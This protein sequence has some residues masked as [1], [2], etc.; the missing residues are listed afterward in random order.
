[1]RIAAMEK[2]TMLDFP[3]KVSALLFTSA[4]NFCCPYCHNPDLVVPSR[5][6]E[7]EPLDPAE[8]WSFLEKRR[9]ILQGIAITGGEPTLQPD[10][11]DF[12]KRIKSLGYAVKTDTNG[13]N[14]RMLKALFAEKVLD[15]IAMDI[16]AD[17]A[18]YP[19]EISPHPLGNTLLDSI[20][21][22]EASGIPHEFRI[23]CAAPFI[24]PQSFAVILSYIAPE[25]PIYLQK[26]TLTNVLNPQ[27]FVDKK[28]YSLS[29]NEIAALHTQGLE[30]GHNVHIRGEN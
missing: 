5:L 26:I 23:P 16:K 28:G 15:Y 9:G 2:L 13:T 7:L 14:P 12:C 21:C 20:A 4:C 1:M 30:S 6:T 24:T 17:P 29:A 10:M 8:L 27:F 22:I 19:K 25:T 3:G 18:N 11:V